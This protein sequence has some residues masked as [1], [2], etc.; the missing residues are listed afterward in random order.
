MSSGALVTRMVVVWKG[1]EIASK[2]FAIREL[3]AFPERVDD[4]LEEPDSE[5]PEI[6][7]DDT[8]DRFF[9]ST[10]NIA[11]DTV[12]LIL[13]AVEAHTHNNHHKKE[14]RKAQRMR[15]ILFNSILL[16]GGK[17]FLFEKRFRDELSRI[18][19]A[20]KQDHDVH[21]PEGRIHD[22]I[23]GARILASSSNAAKYFV[24]PDGEAF[25]PPQPWH[26]DVSL[27]GYNV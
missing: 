11:Q 27:S 3:T 14:G 19:S 6:E 21:A 7:E 2:V 12:D 16:S 17:T 1:H 15:T 4:L 25:A 9:T 8:D 26:N 5:E 13:S 23:D 10:S 22:V 20:I 18:C 24:S